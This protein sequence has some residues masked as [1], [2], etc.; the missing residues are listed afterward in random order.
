RWARLVLLPERVLPGLDWLPRQGERREAGA[1]LLL[2]VPFGLRLL[3]LLVAAHLTLG[4]GIPPVLVARLRG[5]WIE[6]PPPY[7]FKRRLASAY[8]F[9]RARRVLGGGLYTMH[10]SFMPSG[11]EK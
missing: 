3:L 8:F 6:A 9:L 5:E 10:S 1:A 7:R 11:S 2:L 4:H